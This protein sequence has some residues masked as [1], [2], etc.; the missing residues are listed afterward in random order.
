[1]TIKKSIFVVGWSACAVV[2]TVSPA[3]ALT[4]NPYAGDSETRTIPV[5]APTGASSGSAGGSMTGVGQEYIGS[6]II[7]DT[8][9]ILPPES[10][11]AQRL[12]VAGSP[13]RDRNLAETEALVEKAVREIL[14]RKAAAD[15]G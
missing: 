10:P 4:D 5:S 3:L 13:D 9:A 15:D 2:A 11:R 12:Q 8:Y 14:A 6:T 7:E 1:M